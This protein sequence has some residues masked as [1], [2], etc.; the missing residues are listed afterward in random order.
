[1]K[2]RNASRI[3]LQIIT[4]SILLLLASPV[5]ALSRVPKTIIKVGFLTGEEDVHIKNYSDV[6]VVDINTSEKE[7]LKPE[8]NYIAKK[9]QTGLSIGEFEFSNQVRL[10]SPEDKEFIRING[11]RYRDTVILNGMEDGTVTAVNELGVDGYLFGVLPVEVSPEWPIEALK[12]QAVVSRTFVMNNIGKYE[13]AGYDLSSDVFS[14][15]YRGVEV[16]D[17]S[18][19]RAV[20]ETS[21]QVLT[22]EGDL[23][24]AYFYSSCGGYTADI[25]NVWGTT[26]P[27]MEGVTCGFCK[28]SPRYRWNKKVTPRSLKEKLNK[29]G[30]KIG[31]IKD[32]KFLSRTSSGRIDELLVI[33]SRGRTALTGHKFRMAVGP[34]IIKSTLM[35]IDREKPEFSFYGRGWGHGVGMCQWGAKGMAEKGYDY[36]DILQFYFPGVQLERWAY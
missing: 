32:I 9:G 21:G 7:E 27:Y 6:K 13:D 22:Y 28:D 18:S 17:P 8:K 34:D 12:A 15:V 2:T 29:E 5:F 25:K 24:K 10:S 4:G 36:V 31:E 35:S 14:Q 3:L 1:M 16:E 33:H 11:R 19:N 30:Y 23:A 26:L 20:K